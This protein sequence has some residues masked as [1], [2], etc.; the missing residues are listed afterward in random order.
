MIFVQYP[1]N[2][3]TSGINRIIINN[4]MISVKNLS[5][6][7][8][9]DILRDINL[10]IEKNK[11]TVMIGP[12][13]AGKTTFL[14]ILSGL[15]TNYSGT[16]KIEGKN[17]N[18]MRKKE[19]A[20]YISFQPQSEEFLLPISVSDILLSGRFP[21]RK[22]FSDYKKEDYEILNKCLDKFGIRQFIK[23]DINTLSSGERR[24]VL[25]ASAYI[26]DVPAI[27]FDEP[28]ANLDPKGISDLRKIF[29]ELKAEGK[30]I[31]VVSHNLDPLYS[32]TDNLIAIKDGRILYN[33]NTSKTSDVLQKTF[34]VNFTTVYF[35][36][37]A[38][39][40]PDEN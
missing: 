35:K 15:I 17:I 13:G 37:K 6:P 22:L 1:G 8:G 11:L 18:N 29:A 31:V 2:V 20:A 33:G 5:F 23:R 28:F 32:I 4:S 19:L 40:I 12:N 9:K 16:I 38:I 21:Y 10:K 7:T 36:E 3:N 26:Q 27:L 14:K 24:K 34:N 39:I 30:T 25:I